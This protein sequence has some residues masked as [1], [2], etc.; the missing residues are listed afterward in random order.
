MAGLDDEYA[1]RTICTPPVAR[2]TSVRSD[3]MNSSTSGRLTSSSTCTAP[4]GAP[5]STAASARVRVASTQQSRAAGCGL[6]TTALRVI[7]AQS[8]LKYTVA[9]GLVDGTRAK[10][11]PA[12][13]GILTHPVPSSWT[14][15][16]KFQSR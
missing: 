2:I 6:M 11:T 16:T 1:A 7:N 5:A 8:T 4:S 10:T 3:F 12:G 15:S 13:R 9:I 14:G